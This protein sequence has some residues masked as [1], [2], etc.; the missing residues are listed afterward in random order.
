M[1]ISADQH[2]PFG[3]TGLR[4][5]PIL[6]G[7]CALGNVRRV[8]PEQTKLEICGDWFRH[9]AP[10]VFIE[11]SNQHGDGMALKGLRRALRRLEIAPEE[12]VIA[13]KLGWK[14][15]RINRDTVLAAWNETCQP[16]GDDYRPQLIAID[17]S[18]FLEAHSALEELK[19]AGTV[20]GI[21]AVAQDWRLLK[22]LVAAINL[23]W[24][25]LAGSFTVMRHPPELR[26][27]M[28]DLAERRIA[29]INSAV[30]HGGFLVGASQFNNR[31]VNVND[32]ADSSLLAW[33]KAFTALCHGHSVR[34]SH[35]CIQF[36]L[37]APGVVAVA[38]D[39]SRPNRVAEN[40]E[41]VVT[42]VPDAFWLA[43]KEERLLEE[44]YPIAS[45]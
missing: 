45:L 32:P 41:S 36:A 6:F 7:S 12:M 21:G 35:A 20:A 22:D 43:M 28:S 11:T 18:D 34:L 27:F 26:Q 42:K 9:V 33:R 10:P 5:P 29:I 25:Q 2:R 1:K 39:T 15:G 3:S 23:D 30:F 16:L 13:A 19:A 40:V 14:N 37:S 31:A 24:V 8:I 4:V 44:D 17:V 38:L